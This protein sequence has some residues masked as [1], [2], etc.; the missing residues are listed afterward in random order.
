M[1]ISD[2]ERLRLEAEAE[3]EAE[4]ELLDLTPPTGFEAG[5]SGALADAVPVSDKG[6]MEQAAPMVMEIG[7]SL[8]AQAIPGLGTWKNLGYL[9]RMGNYLYKGG[10]SALGAY[11]GRKAAQELDFAEPTTFDQDLNT[12]AY[13]AMWDFALPGAVDT[14]VSLKRGI[15]PPKKLIEYQEAMTPGATAAAQN[16]PRGTTNKEA[17][18]A[19]DV[20]HQED[21]PLIRSRALT[22]TTRQP[23]RS[24]GKSSRLLKRTPV[25]A[26]KR[27]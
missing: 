9:K 26:K 6:F 11:T 8:A 23:S 17:Q 24:T 5:Q 13:D 2:E 27:P 12:A 22:L 16:A 20:I 18:F 14:A 15:L 3:A 4:L 1:A 7:G 25:R 10:Q 19:K 21:E